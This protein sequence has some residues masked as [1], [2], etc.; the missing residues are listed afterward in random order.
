MYHQMKKKSFF[1]LFMCV[2]RMILIINNHHFLIQYPV[3][4]LSNGSIHVFCEV[5]NESLYSLA[6]NFGLQR[7]N[8]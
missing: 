1:T 8:Y 5:R 2:V 6:I 4:S 3:I 7:V